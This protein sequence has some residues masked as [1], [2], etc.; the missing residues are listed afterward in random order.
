MSKSFEDI[1]KI[2]AKDE[3]WKYTDI[4]DTIN[5]FSPVSSF[6]NLIEDDEFEIIS[7]GSMFIIKES[8]NYEAEDINSST[9]QL[10]NEYYKRPLDRFIAQQYQKCTGGLILNLK[11]SNEDTIKVDF[12][13]NG[14]IVPY[15]GIRSFK[16]VTS[17]ILLN[18]GEKLKGNAFPIIEVFG[19]ENSSLELIV[20]TSSESEIEII[21]TIFAE[22]SKD[23]SLKIHTVST[24]GKFSRNRIDVDLKGEGSNFLID[25]VY[26]GEKSQIHDNRVF[27]N[28]IAKRTTSNMLTKGVLGDSSKSVFTGTIHI[29]E[30]AE[31]TESHQENRNILL[32][33]TASAQSVPNL[34]ILCDDVICGHG[35]SV[36]PLEEKLFHYVMS[37]GIERE[38]AEKLLINGFFNEVLKQD[39]WE[40]ISKTVA[41]TILDKYVKVRKGKY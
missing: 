17:K 1:A 23:A 15:L 25:G 40:E 11:S 32:S 30:G 36:G 26:F 3:D 8:N 4:A 27:V 16:N 12:H 18:F 10:V 7:N 37:R 33:D 13:S 38:D 6:T 9:T 24:G 41:K 35:S 31:K 29:A 2:S 19:E 20:N 28:H 14:L 5:D 34:E 21:N 22:L 39:G